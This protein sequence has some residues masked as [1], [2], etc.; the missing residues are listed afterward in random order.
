MKHLILIFT[1]IMIFNGCTFSQSKPK[2]V[3]NKPKKTL[4]K[5]VYY[6]QHGMRNGTYTFFYDN[7]KQVDGNYKN[8]LKNGEW[9]FYNQNGEISITGQYEH[10]DKAGTWLYYRNNEIISKLIYSE[11]AEIDTFYGYWPDGQIAHEKIIDRKSETT[12][13]IQFYDNGKPLQ[14]SESI[15]GKL[16]GSYQRYD[17]IGNLVLDI[18]YLKGNP[19]SLKLNKKCK[20]FPESYRGDLNE[21]NGKLIIDKFDADLDDFFQFLDL[22][23]KGGLLDGDYKRFYPSGQ[24]F[25]HGN[26]ESNYLSGDFT[27]YDENGEIDT[28]INY[29]IN[30]SIEYDIEQ[31]I[32][33][34][35]SDGLIIVEL[36]P[37]FLGG[38]FQNFRYYIQKNLKYPMIAVE[39]GIQGKVFVQFSVNNI[40]EL[41][42]IKVVKGVHELLDEESLRVV[43][44]SPYWEPGFQYAVPVK[45]QFTF[46]ITFALQ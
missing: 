4:N 18:E 7:N 39:N 34:N 19:Y 45:V 3:I 1:T 21:G 9:T 2:R 29:S 27:F 8:D 28:I 11:N 24:L 43:N 41:E 22:N 33:R 6:I 20:S 44:L 16:V 46:P 42:D 15:N 32:I 5:E 12:K 14:I 30:D 26:Y 31:G 23:F 36:M 13:S 40:G 10:G 38:E 37:R 25:C 17:S 35:Y